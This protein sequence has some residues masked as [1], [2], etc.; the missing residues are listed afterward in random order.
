VVVGGHAGEGIVT[1]LL[2]W[3]SSACQL[4]IRRGRLRLVKEVGVLNW[5]AFLG[6]EG[7][8]GMVR[9]SWAISF[10]FRN[11][12]GGCE[13]VVSVAMVWPFPLWWNLDVEED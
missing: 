10:S 2:G 7:L 9:T 11:G 4:N 5:T 8:M 1:C 12:T 6:A 13:V 3:A